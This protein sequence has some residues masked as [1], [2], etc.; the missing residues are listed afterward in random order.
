MLDA[1]RAAAEARDDL[2]GS[3][4]PHDA[5]QSGSIPLTGR[6]ILLPYNLHLMRLP[7]SALRERGASASPKSTATVIGTRRGCLK[8]EPRSAV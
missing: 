5:R 3:G 7:M 1:R 4:R 2:G 6:E 8:W